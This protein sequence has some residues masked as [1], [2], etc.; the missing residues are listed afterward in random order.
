MQVQV[1]TAGKAAGK[2]ATPQRK[3]TRH[4]FIAKADHKQPPARTSGSQTHNYRR[5]DIKVKDF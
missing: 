5:R 1:V 4:H 3:D 2:R